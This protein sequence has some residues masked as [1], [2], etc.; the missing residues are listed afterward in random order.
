MSNTHLYT[1]Q[2]RLA[3]TPPFDFTKSLQ[4]L[5]LFAPTQYEQTA[6]GRVLTKALRL[7]EHTLVFEVMADGSGDESQM[8]YTLHTSQPLD[9]A[10]QHAA[11]ERISFFLS[12]SDDLE[13]FYELGRKDR[14]FAP[15]IEQLYGYHQVKFLTP[16]EN[17]CW[18]VLSQRTPIPAARKLKQ[19]LAERWGGSVSLKQEVYWAFPEP[20]QLVAATHSELADVL[21]NERKAAYIQAV[22]RA[23]AEVDEIWL[24]R[25]PY[26]EVETWLRS[27]NGIGPWS[28]AFVLLRGLGR[29]E[30]VPTEERLVQAA[31]QIYGSGKALTHADVERLAAAYGD[32][33]GYWAHYLRV[34]S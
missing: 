13:P 25:A 4:F 22:S 31:A 30:R 20:V 10:T 1:Y 7:N 19:T 28:A 17:A 9:A 32:Y 2:G 27:I 34:A 11:A 14:L 16:F 3:V 6:A 12:L 18:A 5:G 23:F 26:V 8:S 15:I 29:M 24:R 21:S 33:Q